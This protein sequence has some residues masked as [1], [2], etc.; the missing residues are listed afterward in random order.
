MGMPQWYY[1]RFAVWKKIFRNI[2]Y[3][4]WRYVP[5]GYRMHVVHWLYK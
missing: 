4:Q 2:Q 3:K 1:R 5:D